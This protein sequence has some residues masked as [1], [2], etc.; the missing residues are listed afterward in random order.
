MI[1]S[2][3]TGHTC[4]NDS[5]GIARNYQNVLQVIIS[6]YLLLTVYS[7]KLFDSID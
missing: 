1:F 4:S 6:C 7:K 5:I 3:C 2:P